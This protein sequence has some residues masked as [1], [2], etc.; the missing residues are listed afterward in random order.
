MMKSTFLKIPLVSVQFVALIFLQVPI[1]LPLAEK[2]LSLPTRGAICHQDHRLC[3]CS[4]ERIANHT[5]CCARSA[6]A[7]RLA[8]VPE[9]QDSDSCCHR[10]DRP[11]VRHSL[12]MAP[13]GA[14]SPLFVSSVQDYLF[15]QYPGEISSPVMLDLPFFE[16]PGT[17]LTGYFDPPDPPPRKLYLV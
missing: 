9:V 13:C 11:T 2:V 6:E 1:F 10:Q 15:F 8:G 16:C 12:M 4:A 3:G 7:A 17:L 5:C 14:A